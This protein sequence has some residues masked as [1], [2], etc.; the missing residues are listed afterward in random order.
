MK[1][2]ILPSFILLLV[3]LNSCGSTASSAKMETVQDSVQ[4]PTPVQPTTIKPNGSFVSVIVDSIILLDG[5]NYSVYGK[6]I[7]ALDQPGMIGFAVPDQVITLTPEYFLDS[8]GSIALTHERNIKLLKF[9]D[10]KPG[11]GFM[12]NIS[13]QEKKGWVITSILDFIYTH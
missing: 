8:S 7:S 2:I 9:R 1:F 12:G 4:K 5:Y 13:L 11:D 10:T 6:I 3:F